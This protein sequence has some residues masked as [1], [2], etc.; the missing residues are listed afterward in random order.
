MLIFHTTDHIRFLFKLVSRVKGL[1]FP[2]SLPQNRFLIFCLCPHA[3]L[4]II[5]LISVTQFPAYHLEE[6][7]TT[8]SSGFGNPQ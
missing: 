8:P 1:G 3:T 6:P 5:I 4:I 7:H 2:F